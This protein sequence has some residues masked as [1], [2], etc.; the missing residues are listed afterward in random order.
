L[1]FFYGIASVGSVYG[2][3]LVL[4]IVRTTKS[5]QNVNNLLVAN[6][7]ITDIILAAL[8]TPFQSYAAMTQRWDMPEFMCKLCPFVQNTCVNVNVFNLILI[9]RDRYNA[10][11]SPLNHYQSKKKTLYLLLLIWSLALLLASPMALFYKFIWIS[12]KALGI[13]P[14]CTT[15]NP[16]FTLTFLMNDHNTETIYNEG[17]KYI[18]TKFEIY[19]FIVSIYQYAAPLLYLTFAYSKMSY[20]LSKDPILGP[21]QTIA[22]KKRSIKM[23]IS[24]VVVFAVCWLPWHSYQILTRFQSQN[25]QVYISFSIKRSLFFFCHWL[26]MSNGLYNPFIYALFS[27]NF[28][29]EVKKR[30]I[31]IIC[32]RKETQDEEITTGPIHN[33]Y[34][35][36]SIKLNRTKSIRS[37]SL[38][39]SCE[40]NH[41]SF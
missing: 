31:C 21:D 18:T 19:V 20:T 26:A 27:K 22:N 3:G 2:N 23:M 5:L 40:S 41:D 30:A 28:K 17:T 11:V 10:V 39:K 13:K 29:K 15:F 34:R 1:I 24:L 9:A 6:L 7:A 38:T 14:Y 33:I 32:F 35:S 12:D 37:K 36:S 16:T 8:V 25:F 4:W